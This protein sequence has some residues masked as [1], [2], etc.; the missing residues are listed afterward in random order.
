MRRMT[1]R[2]F[3][4]A[5]EAFPAT[6]RRF[7]S[8]M[9]TLSSFTSRSRSSSTTA[10]SSSFAFFDQ[11]TPAVRPA[12]RRTTP[13][14]SATNSP[15]ID[16]FIRGWG[17]LGRLRRRF[18]NRVQLDRR[19]VRRRRGR[20]GSGGSKRRGRN[21]LSWAAPRAEGRAGGLRRRRTGRHELHRIHDPLGRTLFALAARARRRRRRET[22]AGGGN[23]LLRISVGRSVPDE[24][25]VG[26]A[27]GGSSTARPPAESPGES[28][29]AVT[30]CCSGLRRLCA[31]GGESPGGSPS[32]G[33]RTA[34]PGP[35]RG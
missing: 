4:M 15:L 5:C 9:R 7:P 32:A 16:L 13:M 30:N 27:G 12:A 24:E 33:P 2:N 19:K 17:T 1:S 26:A 18:R 10:C 31:G 29:S 34:A 22:D 14:I 35:V 23:G 11:R 28:P 6:R 8:S 25:G 3:S 21:R 20:C